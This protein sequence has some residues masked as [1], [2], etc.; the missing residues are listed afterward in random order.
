MDG[1]TECCEL[2]INGI[3]N[4][5]CEASQEVLNE[6]TSAVL[7]TVVSTLERKNIVCS[8][9]LR[10]RGS[11][12]EGDSDREGD[13]ISRL[14]APPS[15]CIVRLASPSLVKDVM[16]AKRA[17]ENNY[18]TTSNIKPELLGPEAASYVLKHK[19]LINEMLSQDKF[20]T[21]KA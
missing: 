20:L 21:S 15:S 8:R 2:I 19:I 9:V 12:R 13:W 18:L 3:V 14:R 16:R 7:G 4:H 5:N 17:F 11:S 6:I 1:G 10:S